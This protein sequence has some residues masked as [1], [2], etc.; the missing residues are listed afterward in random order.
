MPIPA[1]KSGLGIRRAR[2]PF[3]L[4]PMACRRPLPKPAGTCS[5]RTS[6]HQPWSSSFQGPNYRYLQM[7]VDILP[8]SI[9]LCLLYL[10]AF[11]RM[12]PIP[13]RQLIPMWAAEGFLQLHTTSTQE[14][15]ESTTH[16]VLE[17]L[18]SANLDHYFEKCCRPYQNHSNPPP[19]LY[20]YMAHFSNRDDF[21]VRR[22]TSIRG[23]VT[24]QHPSPAQ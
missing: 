14:G 20:P 7:F 6:Q 13:T 11:P 1:A 22:V 15:V 3:T 21:L 10:T 12:L 2:N 8:Y 4:P 17:T 18:A 5:T 23:G 16:Q 19:H 24:M 9:K